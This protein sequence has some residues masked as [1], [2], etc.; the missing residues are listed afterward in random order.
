MPDLTAEA[1]N[2]KYQSGADPWDLGCPAPPFVQ[3]LDSS[4]VPKPGRIAVLGCGSG[5]D[6]M[7]FAAAGFE[8][9]GFDFAATAIDRATTAAHNRELNNI[10]FVQRNIFELAPEFDNGFDY[11]LE[12]TCFCALDPELRW[13]YVQ[14]VK[15]LLRPNG[16][17]I[18]LF[19]THN[20]PDGPP[21]SVKPKAVLDL[22]KADFD[23]LSF[24]PAKHSI[25]RRKG[26]EHLGLFQVKFQV[27][28]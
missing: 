22:L 17:L 14:V 23:R 1:W 3:L 28:E 18:A 8:V 27:T 11:V 25:D 2:N 4:Q 9:V 20:R 15:Q 6:A 21:F 16:M 7:L 10:Q 13:D 19:Y 26:E 12:H 24:E 5:Q